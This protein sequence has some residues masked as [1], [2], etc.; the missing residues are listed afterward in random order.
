M[1]KEPLQPI[2]NMDVRGRRA[3]QQ[4]QQQ[5]QVPAHH[6]DED[7]VRGQVPCTGSQREQG[8]IVAAE[9]YTI[10]DPHWG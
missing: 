1:H 3:R 2:D 7:Q 5:K 4:Q 6:S 9:V 10:A 8:V